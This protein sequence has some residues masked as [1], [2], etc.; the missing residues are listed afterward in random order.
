MH[1]EGNIEWYQ[2]EDLL[3]SKIKPESDQASRSKHQVKG[4]ISIE[5]HGKQHHRIQSEKSRI[6]KTL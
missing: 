1:T 2:P 5:K 3:C 4:N 6:W